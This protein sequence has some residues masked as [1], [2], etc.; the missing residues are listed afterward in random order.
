MYNYFISFT[1]YNLRSTRSFSNEIITLDKKLDS[2]DSFLKAEEILN[3]YPEYLRGVTILF[4]HL[5]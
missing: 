5:L 2:K 3:S 4:Y 1:Y